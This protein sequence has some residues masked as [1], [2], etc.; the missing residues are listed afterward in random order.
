MDPAF[1]DVDGLR[2]PYWKTGR[3]PA[4]LLVHGNSASHRSYAHQVADA[5]LTQRCTLVT[6]DLAGHGIASRVEQDGSG[7]YSA[8]LWVRGIVALARAVD[9]RVLAGHSMGG[10]LSLEAM[11][12]LPQVAGVAIFGTPPF[13]KPL[14]MDA[15]YVDTQPVVTWFTP[16]PAPEALEAAAATFVAPGNNVPPAL[17]EDFRATHPKVRADITST[18]QAGEYE[19]EVTVVRNL[20]VPLAILHGAQDALVSGRYLDEL[21]SPTLWRNKVQR[22]AAAGHL[23][24]QEQPESFNKILL[25]FLGDVLPA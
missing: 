19:D 20:R 25:D 7:G 10:H 21:Q 6:M 13:G 5:R 12:Q 15:C 23:P 1:L 2:L 11:P 16:H 24:H 9:A 8:A 22:I 17:L 3:G 4:V 18:L 14:Q